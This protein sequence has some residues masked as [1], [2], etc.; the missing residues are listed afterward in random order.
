[1][2]QRFSAINLLTIEMCSLIEHSYQVIVT[3][4]ALHDTCLSVFRISGCISGIGIIGV[5]V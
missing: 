5:I 3:T 2:S 4:N 1:M